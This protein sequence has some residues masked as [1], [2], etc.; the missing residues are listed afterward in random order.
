[1]QIL[2][3]TG[4]FL[5]HFIQLTQQTPVLAD[6][7]KATGGNGYFWRRLHP[8]A[9]IAMLKKPSL[10]SLRDIKI[11]ANKLICYRYIIISPI[12]ISFVYAGF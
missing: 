7:G 12:A 3:L 2:K 8:A 5:F 10:Q 11:V 4:H 1:M 9:C 6:S